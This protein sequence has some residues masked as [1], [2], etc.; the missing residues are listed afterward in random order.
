LIRSLNLIK[1][2][3]SYPEKHPGSIVEKMNVTLL[4]KTGKCISKHL[5]SKEKTFWNMI[6]TTNPL[7]PLVPK[8]DYGFVRKS[9][10][11]CDL[12]EVSGTF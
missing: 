1:S 7:I 3:P 4:S 5:T 6:I 8:T 2:N 9:S 10:Q 12:V 11:Y